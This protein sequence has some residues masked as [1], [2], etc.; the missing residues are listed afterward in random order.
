M[1]LPFAYGKYCGITR[2]R[3]TPKPESAR[4]IIS[5]GILERY[6]RPNLVSPKYASKLDTGK[7][8]QSLSSGLLA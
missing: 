5:F 2:Y 7:T 6:F 8:T 1:R 4:S 3:L